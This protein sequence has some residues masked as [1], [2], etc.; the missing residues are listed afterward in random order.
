MI[1]SYYY[2]LWYVGFYHTFLVRP[3]YRSSAHNILATVRLTLHYSRGMGTTILKCSV[4]TIGG[5][6]LIV[7]MPLVCNVAVI[8][9]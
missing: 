3:V 1:L 6:T 8:T 2:K 5:A 4:V 9:V 7:Y